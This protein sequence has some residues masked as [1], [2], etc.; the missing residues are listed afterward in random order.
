MNIS[1]IG[2]N[3]RNKGALLMLSA[4]L[5]IFSELPI[6]K[7]FVFTPFPEKDEKFIKK[8]IKQNDVFEFSIIKWHQASILYSFFLRILNI[9]FSKINKALSESDY[10]IDISGISFVSK[11]GFKHLIYNSL[12]VY[13]PFSNKSKILKF[14]QSI[15]PVN[16]KLYTFI[17]KYFLK[18]CHKIFARGTLTQ[19]ELK[20]L[21]IN[22]T[23]STDLGFYF[24]QELNGISFNNVI[25]LN[26]SIVVSGYFDK[27]SIGYL[28]F[29]ENLI[30]DLSKSVSK[31]IVF[32]QSY[33]NFE[34]DNI[35]N[36]T[37]IIDYLKNKTDLKNVEFILEDL[38]IKNL[39]KIY[40]T[41]DICITSRFHGMIMSIIS[42]KVPIVIGWNH[43]Y[44]E[45]LDSLNLSELNI[46][47]NNQTIN[48]TIKLCKN[49]SQNYEEYV[50][51]LDKNKP[52]LLVEE[53]IK[54]IK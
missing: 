3:A 38:D 26:P 42:N 25:G 10:V 8:I 2:G 50:K 46:N 43:K 9:K 49:I 4:C 39:F 11:R 18:K 34:N 28:K 15:G 33:S 12:T 54:I 29:L 36:D 1:I 17:S 45:I 14:P 7:L 30:T 6:N 19:M 44:K 37:K 32:P 35:F 24:N 51:K 13:L 40:D 31:V 27:K 21:D 41:I 52:K 47:I 53:F 23:L 5:E 16:G 48:D 22:S 20:K